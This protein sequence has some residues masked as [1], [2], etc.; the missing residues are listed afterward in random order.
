MIQMA[1]SGLLGLDPICCEVGISGQ[2]RRQRIAL[3]L[4]ERS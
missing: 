2:S 1:Q 3:R 4:G